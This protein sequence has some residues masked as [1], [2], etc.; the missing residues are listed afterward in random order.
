MLGVGVEVGDGREGRMSKAFGTLRGTAS[1]STT[2]KGGT[3][4]D[5]MLGIVV[6]F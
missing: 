3:D 6:S 5:C 1:R 2:G 4:T